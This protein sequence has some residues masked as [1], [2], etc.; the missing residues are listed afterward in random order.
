MAYL[1][2]RNEDGLLREAGI[3]IK[4]V[5]ITSGGTAAGAQEAGAA[6]DVPGTDVDAAEQAATMGRG[7]FALR[8]FKA[9]DLLLFQQPIL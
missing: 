9:G 3:G 7:M 6:S 5:V 4:S 2:E 8:D 1:R